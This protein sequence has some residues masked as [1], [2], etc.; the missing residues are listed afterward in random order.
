M[1]GA[2]YRQ[3]DYWCSGG[4]FGDHHKQPGTGQRRKFA[5]HELLPIAVVA[6]VAETLHALNTGRTVGGSRELCADV[7]KAL[8][9]GTV[10]GVVVTRTEL[11][12]HPT[13]HSELYINIGDLRL[14]FHEETLNAT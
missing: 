11:T 10:E 1:T 6:R 7:V 3:L 12:I 4:I 9:G 13:L 8:S 2:T 14:R 5:A